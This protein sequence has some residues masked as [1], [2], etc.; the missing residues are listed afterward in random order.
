[1]ITI[2]ADEE[3]KDLDNMGQCLEFIQTERVSFHLLGLAKGN[4][5]NGLLKLSLKFM[6]SLLATVKRQNLLV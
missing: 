3:S 2:L 1:M 5:P 4:N 6:I